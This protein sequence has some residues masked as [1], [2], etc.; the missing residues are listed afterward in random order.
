MFQGLGVMLFSLAMFS[1]VFI[2]RLNDSFRF[3]APAAIAGIVKLTGRKPDDDEKR[4]KK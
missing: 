1:P 2:P 4:P 3:V